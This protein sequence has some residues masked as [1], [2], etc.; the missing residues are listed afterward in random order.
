VHLPLDLALRDHPEGHEDFAE[1]ALVALALLHVAGA[2][3]V[4]LGD[5]AGAEQQ[6]A[7]RV[8]VAADLRRHDDAVVEVDRPFVVAQLRRDAQRS[9]LPAQVEQLEDVV[10]P[11]LA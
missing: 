2:L 3:E 7:E 10:D 1:P 6:R 4:G 8:R 9:R 5:L 11:E